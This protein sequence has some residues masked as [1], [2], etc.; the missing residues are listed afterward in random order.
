MDFEYYKA[1]A[2]EATRKARAD[3]FN[4]HTYREIACCYERLAAASRRRSVR[5][6]VL[7]KRD[8]LARSTGAGTNPE[9]LITRT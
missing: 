8:G 2:A 7:P 9:I 1:R 3:L 4:S 5:V 6:P